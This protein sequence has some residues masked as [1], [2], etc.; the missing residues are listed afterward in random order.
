MSTSLKLRLRSLAGQLALAFGGVGALTLVVGAL[1][2]AYFAHQDHALTDAIH[3]RAAPARTLA[4]AEQTLAAMRLAV[5]RAEIA[6]RGDEAANALEAPEL[7][8]LPSRLFA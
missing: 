6:R 4:S 5:A 3:T 7:A 2:L 1:A 8:V